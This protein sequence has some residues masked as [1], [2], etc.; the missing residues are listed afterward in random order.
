MPC[1]RTTPSLS[2]SSLKDIRACPN[3]DHDGRAVRWYFF[4]LIARS[5]C[6]R[7]MW[8]PWRRPVPGGRSWSLGGTWRSQSYPVSGAGVTG[9]VAV[10]ELSW[11]LVV[12]AG[13]T[14][15]VAAPKLPCAKRRESG[16]RGTWR[17]RSCRGSWW[18]EL[19]PR[20]TWRLGS[21]PVP[22]DGSCGTRRH[23]RPSYL[24]S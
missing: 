4:I 22:G 7:G 9:H 19:E 18:R 23:V 16:P 2:H 1:R 6:P 20:G 14:R 10:P 12:G 11:V 13:A 17:S 24:S 8:Q 5:S 21:Y 3:G 15:H